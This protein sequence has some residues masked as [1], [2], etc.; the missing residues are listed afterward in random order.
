MPNKQ[1]QLR[2]LARKRKA[3]R[4]PGY[5]QLGEFH[6]EAYE[7]DH[8][9]PYTKS[10]GNREAEVFILLQDWASAEGL[11]SF[12]DEESVRLGYSPSLPTNRKLIDL[13]DRFFGLTLADTYATNLFPFIKPGDMSASIPIGDLTRAGREFALPQISIIQPRLVVCLGLQT[14]RAMQ[15]ATGRNAAANLA[16]AISNPFVF[17]SATVWCQAHTGGMGQAN[18]NRGGVD[19]VS[20]DWAAMSRSLNGDT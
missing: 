16:E 13:L 9:S 6:D 3:A 11:M 4:W 15:R 18:R 7:C 19:R 20:A 14:F 2:E 10:A 8:V 5:H 12:F 1:H 17:E